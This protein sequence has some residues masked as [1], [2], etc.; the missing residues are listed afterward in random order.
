MNSLLLL[1]HSLYMME[2]VEEKKKMQK[3][4]RR[5]YGKNTCSS[6]IAKEYTSTEVFLYLNDAR[7]TDDDTAEGRIYFVDGVAVS[8]MAQLFSIWR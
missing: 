1:L 4:K 5:D 8:V 3:R 2:L 7:L 6:W